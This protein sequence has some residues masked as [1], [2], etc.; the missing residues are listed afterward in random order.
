MRVL[1]LLA[2]LSKFPIAD[3]RSSMDGITVAPRA[4]L[5]NDRRK[6][7]G[8]IRWP[9]AAG[10]SGEGESPHHALLLQLLLLLLL[11]L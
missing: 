4:S 1:R 6:P 3:G 11:L 5:D 2:A 7:S 8:R 9:C 10:D